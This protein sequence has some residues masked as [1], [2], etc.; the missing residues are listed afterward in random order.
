[1]SVGQFSCADCYFLPRN[2]SSPQKQITKHYIELILFL[3]KSI[4]ANMQTAPALLVIQLT[5]RIFFSNA[6]PFLGLG[7]IFCA[8]FFAPNKNGACQWQRKNQSVE[9]VARVKY[10]EL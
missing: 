5:R 7:N 1:M 10:C 9:S 4:F 8:F 6:R 2:L 3:P